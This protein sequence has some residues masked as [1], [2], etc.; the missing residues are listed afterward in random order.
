MACRVREE[1]GKRVRGDV[2]TCGEPLQATLKRPSKMTA[3]DGEAISRP[4]GQQQTNTK[5]GDSREPRRRLRVAQECSTSAGGDEAVFK[6]QLIKAG[7]QRHER[8]RRHAGP[9]QL[10]GQAQR[11]VERLRQIIGA[12]SR[13]QLAPIDRVTVTPAGL[14]DVAQGSYA[15][16]KGVRR[17]MHREV[18]EQILVTE[19]QRGHRRYLD[20]T[21][22]RPKVLDRDA[23]GRRLLFH[24]ALTEDVMAYVE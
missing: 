19:D 20:R 11:I 12:C 7:S 22:A 21:R 16:H 2:E 10:P 4:S 13:D 23:D 24:A 5:G 6:R 15:T 14:A 1:F 8:L 17:Q 3:H 9:D 18:Q